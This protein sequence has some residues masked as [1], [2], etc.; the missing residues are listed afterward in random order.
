MFGRKEDLLTRFYEQQYRPGP[1]DS[2][3]ALAYT[4]KDF[5]REFT[6]APLLVWALSLG[7]L[8]WWF[9]W[10][11]WL[12]ILIIGTYVAVSGFSG[13]DLLELTL[14]GNMVLAEGAIK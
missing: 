1:G 5:L 7:L 11:R 13:L 6:L 2:D 9:E 8:Y 14:H 10:F 4:Q 12:C 3:W